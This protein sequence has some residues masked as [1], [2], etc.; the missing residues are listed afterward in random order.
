MS[1]LRHLNWW[2]S[3]KPQP[4]PSTSTP[5]CW[6]RQQKK[7]DGQKETDGWTGKDGRSRPQRSDPSPIESFSP[8]WLLSLYFYTLSINRLPQ[9]HLC[10]L[11][12][13]HTHTHTEI[14]KITDVDNDGGAAEPLRVIKQVCLWCTLRESERARCNLLQTLPCCLTTCLIKSRFLWH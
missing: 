11:S 2:V 5:F 4:P 8:E 9:T 13:W 6:H 10:S 12:K 1:N 3:L 7:T 14:H